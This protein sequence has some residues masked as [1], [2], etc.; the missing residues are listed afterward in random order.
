MDGPTA[1]ILFLMTSTF[2]EA[3]TATGLNLKLRHLSHLV[4]VDLQ[5]NQGAEKY[6]SPLSSAHGAE[7]ARMRSSRT[8]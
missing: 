2:R 7:H 5:W 3:E 6:A 1:S 8:E 4:D